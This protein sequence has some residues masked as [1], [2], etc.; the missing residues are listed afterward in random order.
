MK[1]NRNYTLPRCRWMVWACL[2]VGTLVYAADGDSISA[3]KHTP[4]TAPKQEPG[5]I[6]RAT[7]SEKT[8]GAALTLPDGSIIK[9]VWPAALSVVEVASALRTQPTTPRCE[10]AVY[11]LARVAPDGR[12]LWVKSYLTLGPAVE[13]CDRDKLEFTV[14]SRLSEFGGALG[15]DDLIYVKPYDNT[16]WAGNIVSRSVGMR[17]TSNSVMRINA[18]TGELSGTVPPNVRVVDAYEL[19]KIK[20]ELETKILEEL[21]PPSKKTEKRNWE[22]AT[23]QLFI[24]LEKKIFQRH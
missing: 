15:T 17:N 2:F 7:Y 22:R 9:S 19:R 4:V 8:Y 6:V 20:Q 16:F 11:S 5:E 18:D 24:R 1:N 3:Q 14:R 12:E 23:Q 21:P 10:P 13:V